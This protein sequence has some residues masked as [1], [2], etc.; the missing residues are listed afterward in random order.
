MAQSDNRM[1]RKGLQE[2][3]TFCSEICCIALCVLQTFKEFCL[4]GPSII[5]ADLLGNTCVLV[6][7]QK[8]M[9]SD[10]WLVDFDPFCLFR[11]SRFVALRSSCSNSGNN[12]LVQFAMQIFLIFLILVTRKNKA[13]SSSFLRQKIHSPSPFPSLFLSSLESFSAKL[14]EHVT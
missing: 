8:F 1:Y 3:I 11:V 7:V 9:V 5:L 6:R 2:Q 10:L 4:F 14:G 13:K 12:R